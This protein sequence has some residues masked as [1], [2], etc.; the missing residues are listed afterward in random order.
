M[1]FNSLCCFNSN[2]GTSGAEAWMVLESVLRWSVFWSVFL[3]G[4][5][6]CT[7]HVAH[8]GLTFPP[9]WN[10]SHSPPPSAWEGLSFPKSSFPA[11]DLPHFWSW[12]FP[13]ILW[14]DGLPGLTVCPELQVDR[15]RLGKNTMLCVCVCVRLR[16]SSYAIVARSKCSRKKATK[17]YSFQH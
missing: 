11:S 2:K 5:G 12:Y 4:R 15:N 13:Q 6:L 16:N 1:W 8:G 14:T 7:T 10:S 3:G 17:F 9:E